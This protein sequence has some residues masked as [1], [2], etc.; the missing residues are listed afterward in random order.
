MLSEKYL[1]SLGRFAVQ[2]AVASFVAGTLLFIG[3]YFF[4]IKACLAAGAVFAAIAFL[5]NSGLLALLVASLFKNPYEQD[6]I[7]GKILAVLA[8]LLPAWLYLSL[9]MSG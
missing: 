4:H 8:N 7:L 2:T 5:A 9:I 6:Y 1:R 3:Y